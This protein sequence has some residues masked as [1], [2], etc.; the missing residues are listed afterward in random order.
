MQNLDKVR[1]FLKVLQKEIQDPQKSG[2]AA[3]R[4]EWQIHS[5]KLDA[6]LSELR[7]IVTADKQDSK[8]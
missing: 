3:S 1:G 5:E 4:M 6:H 7:K 8:S 2:G